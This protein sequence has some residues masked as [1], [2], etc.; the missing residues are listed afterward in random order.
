MIPPITVVV[1]GRRG[2]EA[3]LLIGSPIIAETRSLAAMAV[4]TKS[5]LST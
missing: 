3:D 5:A 4:E 2:R 1:L